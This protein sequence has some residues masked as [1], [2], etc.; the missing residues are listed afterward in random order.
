M[1]KYSVVFATDKNYIQHLAVALAS[2]LENN[3]SMKFIVYIISEESQIDENNFKKLKLITEKYDAEIKVRFF[4]NLN[5]FK[6]E[7]L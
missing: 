3:K 6:G 1:K 4:K 7:P 2:L 5:N